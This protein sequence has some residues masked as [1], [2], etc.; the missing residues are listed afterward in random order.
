MPGGTRATPEQSDNETV[1]NPSHPWNLPAL[2]KRVSPLL[3]PLAVP[4]AGLMRGR[5][6]RYADGRAV[7]F[8][9]SCPCVSVG[10]IAFGGTGKTPLV[11]RLLTLARREGLRAVVLSR[12]Y[13]GRPGAE[14]LVVAS[15]TP[16]GRSG[17]EPLMLAGAFPDVPVIVF[18]RRAVSARFAL[19][20]FAPD[21]I[22][23][24][25]GMQHL[26]VAR[27]M[28]IVLLR[29]ED[30]D[31]DWN[32]VIPSGPWREDE[33]ALAAA[34][35]FAV[36]AS[37]EA[38][39]RLAP[40]AERRL[41][42]FAKPLFSFSLQATGL[43]PLTAE[44]GCLGG[45]PDNPSGN[46]SDNSL[47]NSPDHLLYSQ[48][49]GAPYLLLSGVGNPTG[50]EDTATA[51][52]GRPPLRHIVFADHHSFSE[53]DVRAVTASAAQPVPVLCTAKDAVKLRPLA[54]AFGLYSVWILRVEAAFGPAL[55][56]R[57]DFESW[58]R[59]QW[60]TMLEARRLG[61]GNR[62]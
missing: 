23:L 37:P 18:P 59:E 5:R 16:A 33:S 38:F 17:D 49:A 32:R 14:P 54:A 56:T 40:L 41:A 30:L 3:R 50:V 42:R 7:S 55:F 53:A 11:S 26:A 9:P 6:A 19:R 13:K 35:A 15:D 1:M 29:P 51:F 58:W 48:P 36:K 24:D 57:Q 2:Y 45:R 44:G 20:R 61:A 60:R 31:E 21:L 10:N 43:E 22:I 4:Y 52:M 25:D 12:G 28:D 46:P 47:G 34:S 39:A 8:R 27:D 62:A